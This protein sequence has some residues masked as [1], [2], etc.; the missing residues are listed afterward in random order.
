MTRTETFCVYIVITSS[1]LLMS[2]VAQFPFV[3]F[4]TNWL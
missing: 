1:S 3:T 2:F 4:T